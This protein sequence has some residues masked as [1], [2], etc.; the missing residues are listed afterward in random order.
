M[1][2]ADLDGEGFG[3]AKFDPVQRSEVGEVGA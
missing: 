1:V 2:V 3:L